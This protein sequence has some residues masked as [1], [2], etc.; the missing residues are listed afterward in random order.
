MISGPAYDLALVHKIAR[1]GNVSLDRRAERDSHSLGYFE[2]ERIDCIC[3]LILEDYRKTLIYPPEVPKGRN[4]TYDVYEVRCRNSPKGVE[5]FL[6]IKLRVSAGNN[7]LHIG[8][9]KRS[10]SNA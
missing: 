1:S 8:S 6:Y 5:D 9:F 3:R 4:L 7:W 2:C 10:G